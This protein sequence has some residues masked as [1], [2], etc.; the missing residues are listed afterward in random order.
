MQAK[1]WNVLLNCLHQ[2]LAKN[3]TALSR[4][5]PPPL[6]SLLTWVW[7]TG[8]IPLSG[9]ALLLPP[10]TLHPK[11]STLHL[12]SPSGRMWRGGRRIQWEPPSRPL[13]PMCPLATWWSSSSQSDYSDIAA[14]LPQHYSRSVCVVQP[15]KKCSCGSLNQ[16]D[17]WKL[18]WE[19]H[20]QWGCY[21]Q[22][23]GITDHISHMHAWCDAWSIVYWK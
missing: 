14:G 1:G 20:V 3:L 8:K 23:S 21:A 22:G 5:R 6:A 18:N 9:L 7:S 10:N 2:H 11:T 19:I 4:A 15:T 17:L 12:I 16:R 13:P